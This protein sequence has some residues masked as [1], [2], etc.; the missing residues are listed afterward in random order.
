VEE[1]LDEFFLRLQSKFK[2]DIESIHNLQ[3]ILSRLA[4]ENEAVYIYSCETRSNL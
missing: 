4:S 2:D 1:G 3:E